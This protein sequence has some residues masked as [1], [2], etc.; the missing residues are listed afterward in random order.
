MENE[1]EEIETPVS[2]Y[3]EVVVEQMPEQLLYGPAPT[4]YEPPTPVPPTTIVI[5]QLLYG[6]APIPDEP[7]IAPIP[8]DEESGE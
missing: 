6:P 7:T 5:D 3:E 4:Q 8:F 2:D 1:L